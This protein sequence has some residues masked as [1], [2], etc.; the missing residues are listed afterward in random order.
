LVDNAIPIG[1]IRL[2]L[3]VGSSLSYGHQL[4]S[5]LFELMGWIVWIQPDCLGQR[6]F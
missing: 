3:L 2:K 4:E 5:R 6:W 1:C